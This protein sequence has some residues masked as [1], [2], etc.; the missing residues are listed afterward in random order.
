MFETIIWA[1]DGSE[2]AHRALSHAKSL[3]KLTRA[4][5]VVVH[6]VEAFRPQA[7]GASGR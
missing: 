3:A 4:K 1:T 7:V 5:I 6:S 2:P